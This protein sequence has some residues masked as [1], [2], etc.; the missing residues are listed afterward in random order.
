MRR[1]IITG[2]RLPMTMRNQSGTR[3]NATMNVTRYSASG[4]THISGMLVMSVDMW[5]VTPSMRLDGTNASAIHFAFRA[6]TGGGSLGGTGAGGVAFVG[7][8]ACRSFLLG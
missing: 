5:K 2:A 8:A 3:P 4:I 1:R 7:C 6:Q